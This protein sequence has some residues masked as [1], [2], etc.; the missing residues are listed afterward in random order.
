[1]VVMIVVTMEKSEKVELIRLADAVHVWWEIK[2]KNELRMTLRF[3]FFFFGL[4]N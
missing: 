4:S 3:D 2:D 1:M